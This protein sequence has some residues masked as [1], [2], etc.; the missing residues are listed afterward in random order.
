M[1]RVEEI[2]QL[3]EFSTAKVW[4]S[5]KNKDDAAMYL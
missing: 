5:L 1:R 2:P 3:Q 4:A